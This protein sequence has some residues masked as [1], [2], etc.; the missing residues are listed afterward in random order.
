MPGGV[1]IRLTQLRG[2][3]KRSPVCGSR[4]ST[5]RPGRRTASGF[6]GGKGCVPQPAKVRSARTG[7]RRRARMGPEVNL[8]EPLA[9]EM[10]V[11]LRGR[12]VG[13]AEHLLHRTQVAAAGQ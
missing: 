10:R 4:S 5:G 9:R 1:R 3:R 7:L 2:A 12:N 11:E 8:L 13:V 6:G